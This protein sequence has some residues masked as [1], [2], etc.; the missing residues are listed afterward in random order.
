MRR[1]PFIIL[2]MLAV[3]LLT[4]QIAQ[5][6]DG[7]LSSAVKMHAGPGTEFPDV[8]HLAKGLSV[9]IHG[10]LKTWDW[11]DIT[12]RGNRGW[13][14]AEAVGYRHDNETTPIKEVGPRVGVPEVTFQ[15]HSY[16]DSHYNNTLWYGNRD[17][18]VKQSAS[19][20]IAQ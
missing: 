19:Y 6:A 11:C 9:D 7:K 12:W 5:A 17:A 10:C 18:Y 4:A 14:P 16:W 20:D 15:L 2:G 8:R 1:A 3:P 13:V